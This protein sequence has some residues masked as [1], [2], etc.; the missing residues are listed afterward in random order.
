VK[1]CSFA[2]EN[3]ALPILRQV[4]A[5]NEESMSLSFDR[6]PADNEIECPRCGEIVFFELTRC[7]KC[8]LSL[9][10]PDDWDGVPAE[11]ARRSPGLLDRLRDLFHRVFDKPYPV[12]DLFGAAI[13]QAELFDNL[14]RKTA[15]DRAAA[16]RLVAYEQELDPQGGRVAWLQA[17][18]RR[19]E[20]DNREPG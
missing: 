11:V 17:A 13:N 14:L 6:Q 5:E 9:A 18:I 2:E 1:P 19:W 3:Q 16:E 8:G 12:N 7:P 4:S 20:K 15:G 10:E